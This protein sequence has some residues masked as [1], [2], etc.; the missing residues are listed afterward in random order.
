MK[1]KYWFWP[2]LFLCYLG[3][4][5][6]LSAKEAFPRI[7]VE[8]D[9]LEMRTGP[10]RTFPRNDVIKRGAWVTVIKRK[11]DWYKLK[12]RRGKTGW[13]QHRQL[14]QSLIEAG[15][16]TSVRDTVVEDYIIQKGEMGLLWGIFDGDPLL[17]AYGTWRLSNNWSIELF[18]GQA[19][20]SFYSSEL[21][22]LNLIMQ[23]LHD[24]RILP[25]FSIGLGKFTNTPAKTLIGAPETDALTANVM[26]GVRAYL[27]RNFSVRG[28]YRHYNAFIDDANN[29]SYPEWTIGAGF[30]F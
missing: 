6:P 20:G 15:I 28:Y 22:N 2:L 7:R 19:T 4:T 3:G 26:V 14:E 1:K 27:T 25:F 11:T 5:S 8:A 10:G 12:T 18:Q 24:K 17:A 9:Y 23:P 16:E 30:F 21:T 13:V 29:E